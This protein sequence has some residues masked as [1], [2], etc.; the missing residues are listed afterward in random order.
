MRDP[1]RIPGVCRRLAAVW[2]NVP[3]WRLGQLLVNLLSEYV[4]KTG[5][6]PF[7][8]ED[9]ELV[10]F[11]ESLFRKNDNPEGGA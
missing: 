1:K 3:D 6:D 5:R 2:E 8:P 4:N 10:S 11:F 7:F 9:E